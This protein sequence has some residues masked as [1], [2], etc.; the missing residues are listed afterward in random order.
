MQFGNYQTHHKTIKI[1]NFAA[2][3]AIIGYRRKKNEV[4]NRLG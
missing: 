2:D 4:R 3:L 1:A